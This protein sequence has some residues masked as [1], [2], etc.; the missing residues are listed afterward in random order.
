MEL[1][2]DLVLAMIVHA[3]DVLASMSPDFIAI[4]QYMKR[5]DDD[6]TSS[7]DGG[8]KS[9]SCSS[10][11]MDRFV[12]E[13]PFL[14][15]LALV[16]PF[17]ILLSIQQYKLSSDETAY[18]P[19][20]FTERPEERVL[21]EKLTCPPSLSIPSYCTLWA[22]QRPSYSYYLRPIWTL[23]GSIHVLSA[24]SSDRTSSGLCY[25]SRPQS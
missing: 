2:A 5:D 17:E 20:Q 25:H 14:K 19:L 6:N 21:Y 16:V 10:D 8:T 7:S 22:L 3:L 13:D 15:S 18:T 1:P 12:D 4:A 23:A 9:S 24:S 11:S